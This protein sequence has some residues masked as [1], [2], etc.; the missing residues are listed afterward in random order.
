[1]SRLS[2]TLFALGLALGLGAGLLIGWV[3]AP[4][5][6]TEADLAALAQPHKD[7]AVLMIA[8]RYAA[9]SDTAAAQ[10]A[11]AALGYADVAPAIQ[12]I[13]VRA[14]AAQQPEADLRRLAVLARVLNALPPELQPYLP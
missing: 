9:D 1:M 4:V 11:L 13:A 2:L 6:Y 10:S 5:Q 3:I 7:E 8:S 14:I 12:Q